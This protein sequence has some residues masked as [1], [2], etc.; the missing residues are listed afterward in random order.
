MCSNWS[1]KNINPV[2]LG[3]DVDFITQA[4]FNLWSTVKNIAG[5]CVSSHLSIIQL[6]TDCYMS[7]QELCD[8]ENEWNSLIGSYDRATAD[9]TWTITKHFVAHII[10][11]SLTVTHVAHG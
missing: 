4:L 5:I 10:T 2:L 11:W 1:L 3:K 7:I 8:P 9:L 6:T